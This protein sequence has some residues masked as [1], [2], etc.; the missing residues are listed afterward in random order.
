MKK[1]FILVFI[2]VCMGVYTF[3]AMALNT[4]IIVTKDYAFSDQ[5]YKTVSSS[6]PVIPT[7]QQVFKEQ[8]FVIILMLN[9]YQTDKD[10]NVKVDFDIQIMGPKETVYFEKQ[11]LTALNLKVKDE[12]SKQLLLSTT[13]LKMCF[14]QGDELGKYSI[15]VNI[16]DE[17][18][19]QSMVDEAQVELI[20]FENKQYFKDDDSYTTW[21]N[22]YYKEPFPE[23]AIDAYLYYSQ[24]K[25]S[26]DNNSLLPTLSFFLKVFDDNQYLIPYL[27]NIYNS[28]S[29]K[30]KTYIIYLLRYLN[31]D[32]K[33]FFK[34]LKGEE[35]QTYQ[36]ILKQKL[37]NPFGNITNAIQLDMLWEIY[38]A[39]G[40][41][42]PIKKL[43]D[44]L[45]YNKYITDLT[46]QRNLLLSIIG[47]ASKESLQKRCKQYQ[48]VYDY[49][50]YIYQ[51][52]LISPSV[53]AD[54]KEILGL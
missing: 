40:E 28:Q 53:K 37:P 54:L 46:N 27:T 24:S 39:G 12:N 21:M 13:N 38:F 15:K 26:D 49:C 11:R 14:E 17:V 25:L 36:K 42:Q 52:E 2:I 35:L 32:S 20:N 44:I 45:E 7:I 23:K 22:N 41:Y 33:E 6:T 29:P 16:H 19:Q 47:M 50:Y 43:A 8:Y 30:T 34:S 1:I 51:N 10:K 18:A 5:W 31:Y 48:L 4:K 9:D 3:P